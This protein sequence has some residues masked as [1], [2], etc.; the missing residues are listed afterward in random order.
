MKADVTFNQQAFTGAILV[1]VVGTEF[2]QQLRFVGDE[3]DD[4]DV[5]LIRMM[6]M[7]MI[8]MMMMITKIL[9]ENFQ[10]SPVISQPDSRKNADACL[11]NNANSTTR[12]KN[13]SC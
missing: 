8:I 4:D 1:F 9:Q 10:N 6:M 2:Q 11:V 13:A 5:I 3:Y 12:M 7:M